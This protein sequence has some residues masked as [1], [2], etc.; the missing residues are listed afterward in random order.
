MEVGSCRLCGRDEPLV[1]SH[2]VPRA[3][4]EI[5]RKQDLKLVSNVAGQY[6]KKSPI[7]VY[8]HIMCDSCEKSFSDY[9][10]YA[11]KT[12]IQDLST[13]RKVMFQGRLLA[14]VADKIDYQLLK[15]FSISLLWRASV[16][17]HGFYK[18]VQIGPLEEKARGM[19]LSRHPGTENEFASWWS[20]FDMNWSPAIMD[21]FR[22]R[23][24]GVTAYRFYLG[25]VLAYIKADGRSVPSDFREIAIGPRKG[26]V[27]V[28]RDFEK[29]KDRDAILGLLRTAVRGKN[30]LF[31]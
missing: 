23:W 24:S 7:G 11:A 30:G 15:L 26:L 10:A 25:R 1:Q 13:Y 20:V 14:L 16:S 22:E 31:P 19:L 27:M 6:P 8:D 29:S 18:R 2:I 9:D 21:P 3:F 17:R 4:F 5:G 28:A 12:L